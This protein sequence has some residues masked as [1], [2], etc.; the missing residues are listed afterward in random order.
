M[1]QKPSKYRNRAV[2]ISGTRF[3]SKGEARR[4]A[5]LKLMERGHEICDLK[6][7]VSIPLSGKSG[8]LLSEKGRR[9]TYRADFVYVD[10]RTGFQVIEDFKGY[11][12]PVFKLKRAILEAQGIKIKVTR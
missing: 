11:E 6:R 2:V 8:P 7:Q 4:W 5:E 12:T 9:Y 10:A 1:A 3:D